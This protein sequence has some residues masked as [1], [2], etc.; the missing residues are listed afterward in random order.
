[1]LI[2]RRN[3]LDRPVSV[4][5]VAIAFQLN[6]RRKY[7]NPFVLPLFLFSR[8]LSLRFFY[9]VRSFYCILDHFGPDHY[10]L[11]C[12][13]R[14]SGIRILLTPRFIRFLRFIGFHKRRASLETF[15]IGNYYIKSLGFFRGCDCCLIF[16]KALDFLMEL[17]LFTV[18][19]GKDR[20]I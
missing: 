14:S 4:S 16:L 19:L 6:E 13:F 7:P 1:M 2:L 8:P 17:Q 15:V 3:I 10:S 12:Y 11:R 9:W 20:T 18:I 5:F